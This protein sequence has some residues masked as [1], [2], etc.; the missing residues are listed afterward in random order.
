MRCKHSVIT[1]KECGFQ[2]CPRWVKEKKKEKKLYV[3]RTPHINH[4]TAWIMPKSS[5]WSKASK[6]PRDRL[7]KRIRSRLRVTDEHVH[8]F[9][10][11][12]TPMLLSCCKVS[13]TKISR[14]LGIPLPEQRQISQ[15]VEIE[16]LGAGALSSSTCRTDHSVLGDTKW[17]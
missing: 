15:G 8:V 2:S 4:S 16:G 10:F 7:V 1:E 17:V 9:E 3:I 11:A 14:S 6:F 12:F 13:E 5:V